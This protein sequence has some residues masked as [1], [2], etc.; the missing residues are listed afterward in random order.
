MWKTKKK[1]MKRAA[2]EQELNEDEHTREDPRMAE[3]G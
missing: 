3:I 1:Q 2:M